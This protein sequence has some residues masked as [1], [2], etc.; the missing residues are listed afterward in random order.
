MEG[1]MERIFT[2]R[3]ADN[4][5]SPAGVTSEE[6]YSNVKRGNSSIKQYDGMWGIP[7]P[8]A[9]S[10][11]DPNLIETEFAKI[12]NKGSYT[13]FEKTALLSATEALK[14]STINPASERT[15]FILSTTKGNVS[16]LNNNGHNFSPERVLPGVT[17]CIIA[18]FFNNPNRPIVVSNACISGV[19]AQIEAMRLI[20]N[21]YYDNIVV[22]GADVQSK[23][24]VSG[25][26]SFK[27]LSTERCKPFDTER[28]GLNLGEA[29]ATIIF[30]CKN[31]DTISKEDWVL[32]KGAIRNDAN[33]IS[34]PSRS[35]EGSY[36][37][38][39]QI[40]E[41]EE[42]EKIAF[43]NAHGTSTAYNDE[44]E[45]IAI[46]RAGLSG[47]PV[48]GLKGIYGHPLGAAGVLESIISMKAIDS[49][50]IPAT[51]G[52]ENCGVSVPL[53]VANTNRPTEK[54]SFIKMLSGFGGC[55]AALLYKKGGE[56]WS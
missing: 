46:E 48:N 49:G 13:F 34:G 5:T 11:F 29:A 9:A 31:Y 42:R 51:I 12:N 22:I 19:C 3:V 16:L 33:H 21:G 6:N 54:K 43:I 35:G 2:V 25:F 41:N 17:A 18:D 26:Q 1:K 28:N 8:F 4:I 38:L 53:L 14:Q 32:C 44:M 36:R 55:N 10:L 30:S 45:A 56:L 15:I 39:R 23:F 27:A 7:E 37:V 47:L 50:T 24:I 20:Q 40:M 52:Y